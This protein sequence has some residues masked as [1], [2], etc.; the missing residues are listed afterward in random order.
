MNGP[1]AGPMSPGRRTRDKRA[2]PSRGR[3]LTVDGSSCRRV[4][5]GSRYPGDI[6]HQETFRAWPRGGLPGVSRASAFGADDGE[7]WPPRP[8]C[9]NE[10]R[11]PRA[12][13]RL[14]RHTRRPDGPYHRQPER[15]RCVG[16]HG[17]AGGAEPERRKSP[18]VWSWRTRSRE[19]RRARRL[20][21]ARYLHLI[22]SESFLFLADSRRFRPSRS[23]TTGGISDC[24]RETAPAERGWRLVSMTRNPVE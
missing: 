12:D 23:R 9:R 5:G 7:R 8:R 24:R 14:G 4:T 6:Q 11:G 18:T 13:R 15:G 22:D 1:I 20:L 16:G 2:R 3:C 21:P 10:S 17:E 19:N